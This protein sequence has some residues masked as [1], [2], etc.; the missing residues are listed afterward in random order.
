MTLSN[1]KICQK[2]KFHGVWV[3]LETT[4]VPA[5]DFGQNVVDKSTKLSNIG[6][7]SSILELV[8]CNVLETLPNFAFSVTD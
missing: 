1:T 4:Y 3:E 5:E 7:L 6:T 8:F 2:C